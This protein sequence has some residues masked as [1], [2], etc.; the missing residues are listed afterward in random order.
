MRATRTLP[1]SLRPF[2]WRVVLFVFGYA[3]YGCG[4][5]EPT[6]DGNGNLIGTETYRNGEEIE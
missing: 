3:L 4:A 6:F 1:S 2:G 5:S